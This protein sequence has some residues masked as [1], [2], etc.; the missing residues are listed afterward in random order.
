MIQRTTKERAEESKRSVASGLSK[1]DT[2]I[3]SRTQSMMNGSERAV[4]MFSPKWNGHIKILRDSLKR[5]NHFVP[6]SHFERNSFSS[7]KQ[8]TDKSCSILYIRANRE[9]NSRGN[10]IDHTK[11][12]FIFP[13]FYE[14]RTASLFVLV[15]RRRCNPLDTIPPSL[16]CFGSC[17]KV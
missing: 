13:V 17:H 6:N 15:V 4:P 12:L 5:K 11:P 7:C 9:Q 10:R 1:P 8:K 16:S 3:R 14:M 2:F